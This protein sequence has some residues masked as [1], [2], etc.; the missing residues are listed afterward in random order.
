MLSIRLSRV[1][2]LKQ[3]L[4]RLVVQDHA[5]DPWGKSVEIL[6]NRNPRTKELL[7]N[8]DRVKYWLEK[9]AQPSDTVWN[10]FLDQKLVE[11]K[12]RGKSHISK[13]RKTKMEKEKVA[14]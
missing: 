7:L 5:K 12:K 4:F 2:K 9:G 10:L 1:G 6:G 8:L 3:P 14:A 11:G 13:T